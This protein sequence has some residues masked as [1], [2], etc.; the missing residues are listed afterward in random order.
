[1]RLVAS[2]HVWTTPLFL[3][4]TFFQWAHADTQVPEPDTAHTYPP[5]IFISL[6]TAR[7][8]W[9]EPYGHPWVKTP[10]LKAL[11]EDAI[12]F[13]DAMTIAPT[14]L[15]AHTSM[16]T[17]KYPHNHGAPRN[18]YTVSDENLMLAEILLEAGYHTAGFISSF[19]LNSRFNMHQGFEFYHDSYQSQIPGRRPQN[20]RDGHETTTAVTNYLTDL[21]TKRPPFIFL[22]YWDP[23]A[24]YAPP[25][26]FLS[27]YDH[28]DTDGNYPYGAVRNRLTALTGLRNPKPQVSRELLRRYAAE[29]TYMDDALGT[30]FAD[31]KRRNLYDES[32]IIVTSDHG[33]TLWD[34]QVYFDHGYTVYQATMQAVM[35]VKLPHARHAGKRVSATVANIDFLPTI[36]H[37]LNLP[38]PDGM[39]G[40]VLDFN[41]PESIESASYFGQATKPRTAETGELGW[42][43]QNKA[44][45]IRDGRYTYMYTPYKELE[46]LYDL[47][48]DPKQRENLATNPTDELLPLLEDFRARMSQWTGATGDLTT[49]DERE[50]DQEVDERLEALGYL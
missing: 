49:A 28:I 7:P 36:L 15:A 37:F 23:H 21:H 32:L 35:I 5:I 40:R 31:L 25:K 47:E 22:H 39:D 2:V 10:A 34:H 48:T 3:L 17:G 43:N 8:D 14:T 44:A 1:M 11:A 12:L 13:E 50:T 24:P 27:L 41:N 19:A 26:N 18:G 6:D 29:I 9:L 33:E 45:L 38:L 16:F 42:L 46:E 4:L 30:L 20:E